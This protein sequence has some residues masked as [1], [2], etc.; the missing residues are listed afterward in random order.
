[1]VFLRWIYVNNFIELQEERLGGGQDSEQEV[2]WPLDWGAETKFPRWKLWRRGTKTELL[3][4]NPAVAAVG[5]L[6]D[7]AVCS[8]NPGPATW[9]GK[10]ITDLEILIAWGEQPRRW[11]PGWAR[12]M[13]ERNSPPQLWGDPWGGKQAQTFSPEV[14]RG[15]EVIFTK[16][17]AP[18][19]WRKRPPDLIGAEVDSTLGSGSE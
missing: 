9:E 14:L 1:M 12:G 13:W 5:M 3:D 7:P 2:F 8:L 18:L 11:V 10:W 17:W 16:P 6:T 19:Q 4:R 15:S